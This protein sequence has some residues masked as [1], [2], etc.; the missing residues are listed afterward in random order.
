MSVDR[1]HPTRTPFT[2]RGGNVTGTLATATF[3][4]A[5]L[6][7]SQIVGARM[8]F[9]VGM[10]SSMVSGLR[11]TNPNMLCSAGFLPVMNDDHATDEIGGIEDD[12]CRIEPRSN[13]RARLG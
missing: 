1:K 11:S 8:F 4:P 3:L 10:K 13:S 5:L 12:I 6:S 9:A 2:S 7:V